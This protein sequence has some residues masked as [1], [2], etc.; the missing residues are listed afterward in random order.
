MRQFIILTDDEVNAIKNNELVR[1]PV[2][3]PDGPIHVY[4]C[5]RKGYDLDLEYDMEKAE[6]AG[7]GCDTCKH[8]RKT[9]CE[10]PCMTCD[11]CLGN[12][13]WEPKKEDG[14]K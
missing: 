10:E 9:I 3:T 4:L 6:K 5:T 8:N 13:K 2:D 12:N 14:D 1:A 7:H 11:I